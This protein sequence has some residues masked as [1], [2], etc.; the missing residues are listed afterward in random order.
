MVFRNQQAVTG[1]HWTVIEKSHGHFVFEY[2]V[3]FYFTINYLAE[4]AGRFQDI[5][6]LDGKR[7]FKPYQA[8][9]QTL[10]FGERCD[11]PLRP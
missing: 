9:V 2:D 7:I 1:K 8:L 5:R 10:V 11:G 6:F 3:R 4:E